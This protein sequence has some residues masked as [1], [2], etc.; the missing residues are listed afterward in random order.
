MTD[1]TRTRLRESRHCPDYSDIFP[2]GRL[3]PGQL[4]GDRTQ[5]KTSQVRWFGQNLSEVPD[6]DIGYT[7]DNRMHRT[8]EV[9]GEPDTYHPTSSQ[10]MG[11]KRRAGDRLDTRPNVDRKVRWE[12]TWWGTPHKHD[13]FGSDGPM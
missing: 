8:N 4:I 2:T 1:S 3:D 9:C 12:G 7:F 6:S 5:R 10:P 13:L 11:C